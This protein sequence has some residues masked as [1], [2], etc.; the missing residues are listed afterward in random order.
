MPWNRRGL[1]G[2]VT[3]ALALA[4]GGALRAE[5][6]LLAEESAGIVPI[7]DENRLVI[8]NLKGSVSIQRG[9]TPREVRFLAVTEGGGRTALRVAVWTEGRT[10][11]IGP[12]PGSEEVAHDLQVTIPEPF[13]VL[14][15]G[16]GTHVTATGLPGGLEVRGK[17][18]TLEARG[19]K[20]STVVEIEAGRAL[21]EAIGAAATVH[22][23][24]LDLV[25]TNVAGSVSLTLAGGSAR[26]SAA[27]GELR[28]DVDGTALALK[29]TVEP[30]V[31]ARGGRVDIDDA[32]NA[33]LSLIGTPLTLTRVRGEVQVQTDSEARFVDTQ[34][35]LH[36]DGYGATVRGK[37]NDG[38]VEVKTHAAEINMEDVDGPVRIEGDGLKIKLRAV[39]GETLVY[40]KTSDVEVEASQGRLFVENDQGTVTVRGSTGP[41]EVNAVGGDVH[42]LELRGPVELH[43]DSKTAEVSFAIV[44]S[45]KDTLLE[46]VGGDMHVSFPPSAS[47]RVEARSRFGKIESD[48]QNVVTTPDG[49]SATGLLGAPGPRTVTVNSGW[50]IVLTGGPPRP[51]EER[52]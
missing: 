45:E 38:L 43:A 23:K 14:V 36:F 32:F 39:T 26:V 47:G 52:P 31:K 49:N 24:D 5:E 2:A 16:T 35:A 8:R 4:T 51:T 28:A 37:G 50:N 12:R 46:N 17:G 20:G 21:L 6:E 33:D 29:G 7:S 22:G 34:A 1:A 11:R 30:T 19:V 10:L 27:A 18:V 41:V 15:E 3:V 40:V 9:E 42:L 25:L 48:L 13:D 44:P